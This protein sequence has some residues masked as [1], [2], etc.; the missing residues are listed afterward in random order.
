MGSV[1]LRQRR[2]DPKTQHIIDV[3]A[4]ERL[5]DDPLNHIQ[6][7]QITQLA[8]MDL[9]GYFSGSFNPKNDAENLK[10]EILD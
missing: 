10:K 9:R 3:G 8:K 1:I 5:I 6:R 4:E 2:N 7:Q